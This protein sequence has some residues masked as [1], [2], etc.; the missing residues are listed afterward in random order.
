VAVAER[1]GITTPRS[2]CPRTGTW[3]PTRR[4]A[5]AEPWTLRG[6][7]VPR[8]YPTRRVQARDL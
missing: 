1:L 5:P 4:T 3:C 7:R 8:Q 2:C 6:P